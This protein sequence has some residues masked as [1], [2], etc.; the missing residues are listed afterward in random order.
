MIFAEWF[1]KGERGPHNIAI[2]DL[3]YAKYYILYILLLTIYSNN[4]YY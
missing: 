3:Y 2:K 1:Y 4:I